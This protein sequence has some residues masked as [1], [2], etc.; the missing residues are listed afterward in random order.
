M[1][2]E[3]A[4]HA[5]GQSPRALVDVSSSTSVHSSLLHS[6]PSSSAIPR[7]PLF[8]AGL[9]QSI[10]PSDANLPFSHIIPDSLACQSSVVV[11]T[12]DLASVA[13]ALAITIID[14]LDDS[15]SADVA[16]SDQYQLVSEMAG[17]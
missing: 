6:L 5:E 1:I 2:Q 16:Q 12:K 3:E 7:L 11:N 8:P 15:E 13:L 9:A 17:D 14:V 4:L 10:S